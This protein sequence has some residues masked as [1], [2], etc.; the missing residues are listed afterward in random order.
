MKRVL[1]RTWSGV[2]IDER[3]GREWSCGRSMPEREVIAG[4]RKGV[5]VGRNTTMWV[6][7]P[8]RD[9]SIVYF[10]VRL[11]SRACNVR[12]LMPLRA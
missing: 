8:R 6:E 2:N 3:R 9:V 4:E 11:R 7:W 5:W 1:V 12:M 10:T